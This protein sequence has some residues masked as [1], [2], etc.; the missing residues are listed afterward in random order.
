MTIDSE[1]SVTPSNGDVTFNDAKTEMSV[2]KVPSKVTFDASQVFSDLK[3]NDYTITWDFNGDGTRDK[4]NQSNVSY[5]YK[6]AKLYNVDIRFPLLNNYIYTFPIR[7]E[8]S[9]V[10]VCE[11]TA[12]Q[13]KEAQ[14]TFATSFL[15][16][17][18]QVTSY[19]FDIVDKKNKNNIIDTVKSATPQFDYQ[20]PGKGTYAVQTTFITDDGK[21][22]E[23]ESDDIQVGATD[24]QIFYDLNYKSPG[25]PKFQ[26]ILASG[27][28]TANS[29]VISIKEIPTIIQ[30]Q[31]NQIIPNTTTAT[32]KV[33]LDGKSVLSTDGKTFEV[34]IQDSKDHQITI[35]VEDPTRGTKTEES[36]TV[37]VNRSD[38]VWKL[39][40]KPDTVGIDPFTVK[41]DAS[42]TQLNDP[43]DEIVYFTWD[44]WDG[45]I[46]KNL[47]EAI[48]S[49]TYRYDTVNDNGKYHPVLTIETK[50]GRKISISPDTD[51]IVK[52]ATQTLVIN[53]DSNP[54]QVANVNDRVSFSLQ[55]NGLPA[56]IDRDFGN[57]KT[58]KCQGRDC[59]QT[60]QVYT[61]PGTYTIRAEVSYPSQPTVDGSINLKVN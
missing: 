4:Q 30:L 26:K 43:T 31:I 40:V 5:V 39:L 21:Q 19:Q 14:Y 59:I 10:P 17:N 20:F 8:Q 41:F 51:I 54:A 44:F 28:V 29:W 37:Q 56:E 15:D 57:G 27:D 23:C 18:V 6:E 33:L 45:T 12:Q 53:I 38:L 13:N 16:P 1:I 49:H 60:T 22:G 2:G 48:V 52:R 61:T 47:S 58:L 32:K 7:V 35:A 36:L 46:K 3:L 9:D 24:F 50:K 42:T 25:S 55:V 34:T 11:I